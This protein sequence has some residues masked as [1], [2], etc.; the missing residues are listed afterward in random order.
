MSGE[1]SKSGSAGTSTGQKGGAVG[2]VLVIG[3]GISGMQSALDLADAGFRVYI[4]DRS[5]S[6]G[7]AM[8][9]L[10][11]TFPTNDCA[12]CIMAPKLVETGRHQ[13][14]NL[15]MNADL[16]EVSGGPGDF[17]VTVK[18]RPRFVDPTRCTGCGI[19]AQRCPVEVPDEYN[20]GQ[21][22]RKA[23]YI[24]YPQAIPPVFCIDQENC[25]GCGLCETQCQ[26]EAIRYD[27]E[28]EELQFHVGSIVLSPGFSEFDILSKREEYGFGIYPNV[29]TSLGLERMLSATGPFKGH[30]L[31]PSDGDVPQKIAFI[32]CIGSRDKTVGNPYCSTVCCMFAMKEAM[33]AQQHEPGLKSTIFFMDMRAFGKEYEHY[34]VRAEDEYGIRFVRNNRISSVEEVPDTH[35]LLITYIEGGELRDEEFNMVVLAVGME[36]PSEAG[37]L[38]EKLGVKLNEFDFCDTSIFDPLDTS[39]EGIYVSGAFSGPK[40]IPDTVAQ[41]SGAAAMASRELSDAR[42]TLVTTKEYPPERDV[43]GQEPRIGVFV[44]HC[45]INIG[46]VVDVPDVVEYVKTLPDVVHA[47]DNLYTC[48]QDTQKKIKEV[49]EEQELNRVIV[50]S[51]TPRTHEVLFQNTVREAG[52]NPYIFEMANIRD[53]CS[54]VHQNEPDKATQKAKDLIRMA[55][56]RARLL[57]SLSRA[58]IDVNPSAL[59]IGG[60]LSG[61]VSSVE[62]AKQ[63]FEVHLVERNNEL[64]GNLLKLHFTLNGDDVQQYLRDI[65]EQVTS[66][67]LIHVYTG[68]EV[69]EVTGYMGNFTTTLASGEE[70]SQVEHGVIIVA[71]GGTE[72]QTKEHF[73]GEDERVLTQLEFEQKL[74]SGG[75]DAK[76]VV[77]LQCVGSRNDEHPYCSRVCCT[78]AIKNALKFKELN[79]KADVFVLYRDIRSYGFREIYYEKAAYAG[80]IFLRYDDDA[81]PEISRENGLKVK[82]LDT[83]LNKEICIDA[84]LLVLAVATTP[85]STNPRIAQLLKVPLNS[86]GFFLEAH[87]KLRPVDFPTEGLFLCGLCHSPKFIEECVSQAKGAVERASTILSKEQLE[88]EGMVAHVDENTC[89]GCGRCVEACEFKA[90]ELV[91]QEGGKK[92]SHVNEAVCR[93][94]GACVVACCNGSMSLKHFRGDQILA[95]VRA[96]LE[97]SP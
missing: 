25:I 87:M 10:D 55:V 41:A 60:G 4:M 37:A 23:I 66:N 80:V 11:K 30:V 72:Y 74:A 26:A 44:C 58:L 78:E 16:E 91:D 19:C 33:L 7:G 79:P 15:L 1:A 59:V 39:A 52:L 89:L 38:V 90:A 49:I 6:I 97:V 36:A 67:P 61:M 63:G 94:C 17:L 56:A 57:E 13:N 32:Q 96:A 22:L 54:W 12:M 64:G 81:P 75:V 3:G 31:R 34:Y 35:N 46:G 9:Q 50:A 40:D 53:Q 68:T 42:G 29:V 5:P 8:S 51:C 20:Q 84:D 28:E 71:T 76:T 14:I 21:K 77:M 92:V 18:V 45:G 47:E 24:R 73:Y 86:D 48:S 95:M 62:L 43:S 82:V 85:H 70:K 88:S 69:E 27:Q 93:G 83:V 65:V 2:A